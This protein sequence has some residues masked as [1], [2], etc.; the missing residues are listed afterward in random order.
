MVAT[1]ILWPTFALV[2]LIFA[3]W[4]V[5]YVQ[6]IGHIRRNPPRPEDFAT[7]AAAMRYFEP[8]EMPANNLRNLFEMPVLYF[9]LVPLLLVTAQAGPVQVVLA[10]IY[11]VLRAAHSWIHIV[12]KQVQ[13]RFFVFFASCVVLAAMW[14]GF[15]VNI[16]SG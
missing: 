14:I 4:T 7:G 6:R 3:V 10:W 13:P 1:A 5:L 8:V 2:I 15:A 11:V 12:P 16:L 9:A